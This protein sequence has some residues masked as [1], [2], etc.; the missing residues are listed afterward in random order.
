MD[1]V[2]DW[3]GLGWIGLDWIGLVRMGS[4]SYDLRVDD[5]SPACVDVEYAVNNYVPR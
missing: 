2:N 5:N 3:I 1:D 4:L